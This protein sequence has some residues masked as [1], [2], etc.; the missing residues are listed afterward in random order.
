MQRM[1]EPRANQRSRLRKVSSVLSVGGGAR[2]GGDDEYLHARNSTTVSFSYA[3]AVERAL[4]RNY[5]VPLL[6][7]LSAKPRPERD[8]CVEIT[9]LP[10]IYRD[11]SYLNKLLVNNKR[12][13]ERLREEV[14]YEPL[15]DEP[16][17]RLPKIR[18][19]RNN[20]RENSTSKAPTPKVQAASFT[21]L[22]PI[23][24]VR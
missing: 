17:T 6:G 4:K 11:F 19:R 20:S 22:P 13:S 5:H 10:D 8:V 18:S 7:P 14:T 12:Y 23:D 16:K 24:R 21:K 1:M 15:S 3:L 9:R 2:G